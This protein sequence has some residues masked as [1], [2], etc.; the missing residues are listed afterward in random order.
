MK[1]G[2]APP[3]SLTQLREWIRECVQNSLIKLK[4]ICFFDEKWQ[5][6]SF[7]L[8]PQFECSKIVLCFFSNFTFCYFCIIQPWINQRKPENRTKGLLFNKQSV[9]R[10]WKLPKAFDQSFLSSTPPIPSRIIK[11]CR[12]LHLNIFN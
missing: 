5:S 9:H 11:N 8:F 2:D 1:N 6:I 10:S 12:F 4:K 3:T 7:K